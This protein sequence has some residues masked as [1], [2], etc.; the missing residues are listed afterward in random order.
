VVLRPGINLHGSICKTEVAPATTDTTNCLTSIAGGSPSLV[1]IDIRENTIVENLEVLGLPGVQSGGPNDGFFEVS[2]IGCIGRGIGNSR[3]PS[4]ERPV[5]KEGRMTPFSSVAV[6]LSR[7][8]AV[9]FR[10]VSALAGDG[11]SGLDGAEGAMGMNAMQPLAGGPAGNMSY[12]GGAG[13]AS[14]APAACPDAIGGKGGQGGRFRWKPDFAWSESSCGTV[15]CGAFFETNFVHPGNNGADSFLHAGSFTAGPA[16]NAYQAGTNGAHGKFGPNG[17]AADPGVWG[18]R[19]IDLVTLSAGEGMR[20]D[21]GGSGHGGAGGSGGNPATRE[22]SRKSS[23]TSHNNVEVFGIAGSNSGSKYSTEELFSE[24]GELPGGGG[25]A[26]GAG[27]CGGQGGIGGQGGAAS[28]GLYLVDSTLGVETF[29]I[30][31]GKGGEGGQGGAGGEG[32]IGA[33]GSEGGASRSVASEL[34]QGTLSTS[35]GGSYFTLSADG[36]QSASYT[37]GKSAARSGKG[38]TGGA[39]GNG[40][41]GGIGGAGAGGSSIGVVAK[42]ESAITGE[43]SYTLGESGAAGSETGEAGTV[44]ELLTL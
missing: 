42:G 39:G 6:A 12:K 3:L 37:L 20:G 17:S 7:S 22:I 21:V 40:G 38:G 14:I 35:T 26:G 43:V 13:A 41:S 25:G 10:N 8:N 19:E 28:V 4:C 36:Q 29:S 24:V 15:F 30:A 16:Y 34:V 44:V 33:N 23:G 1:G 11:A 31:T 32:G 18:D 5:D 27:G 2:G 9:F